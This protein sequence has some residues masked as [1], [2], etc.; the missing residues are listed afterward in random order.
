MLR[1]DVVGML[2]RSLWVRRLGILMYCALGMT[3][4]FLRV[5]K[6]ERVLWGFL[7]NLRLSRVVL[8]PLGGLR[9]ERV[10]RDPLKSLNLCWWRHRS[11]GLLLWRYLWS[12]RQHRFSDWRLTPLHVSPDL[13]WASSPKSCPLL[14]QEKESLLVFETD[15]SMMRRLPY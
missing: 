12:W 15:G 13:A 2:W 9:L 5:S 7:S 1:S 4:S 10:L 3:L 11:Q 14:G 8:S 6:L